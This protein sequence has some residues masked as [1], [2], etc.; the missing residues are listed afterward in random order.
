MTTPLTFTTALTNF[1]YDPILDLAPWVGQRQASFRF[2]LTNRVSGIKLGEITPIRAGAELTHDTTRVIKRQLD[3]PLGAAD[4]AA[5]NPVTDMVSPFMV[6]PNGQEYALGEYVF[7]DANYQLFTSGELSKMTLN[8]QM[9]IIDQ[10][11]E[12]GFTA[13]NVNL[14]AVFSNLSSI[15]SAITALLVNLPIRFDIENSPF[16]SADSWSAGTTRGT[17]IEALA[18]TGD[19]FSPWFGN[20]GVLHFIRAFNPATKIPDLDW[21]NGDQVLRS[22]I[23]RS[24]NVLTAPNRFVVISNAPENVTAPTFG[25]ADVPQTAPHSIQNRGFVIPVIVDLQALSGIQCTAIASN[26]VQRQTV[27]ETTTL[28]TAPDPRHDSY[29]VVKWQGELWLELAWAMVLV[30]GEPMS[31]TIRKAYR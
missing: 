30:E 24:N 17:I 11:I 9:F 13:K 22:S 6:F 27:F 12:K 7:T 15:P 20:D 5:I 2:D 3:L 26:L 16:G 4:T 21:D 28:T 29:N 18:L 10:Q 1:P 14:P 31:H 19:Y 23:L 8:D 25:S